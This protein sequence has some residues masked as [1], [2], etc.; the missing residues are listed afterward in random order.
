MSAAAASIH[1]M[2]S[3]LRSSLR[4]YYQQLGLL[5][6]AAALHP[7]IAKVYADAAPPAVAAAASSPGAE[8]SVL[9]AAAGTQ[10]EVK[11]GSKGA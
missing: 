3:P 7:E 6:Q 8:A 5:R 1:I 9:P 10:Q 2:S 11:A 4:Q